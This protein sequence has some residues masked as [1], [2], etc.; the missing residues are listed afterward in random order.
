M[1]VVEILAFL[2]KKGI[3]LERDGGDLIARPTAAATDEVVELIRGHKA[4]LLDELTIEGEVYEFPLRL[5]E[6]RSANLLYEAEIVWEE[7]PSDFDYVRSFE[8][9][10]N[11]RKRIAKW[12]VEGRRVGYAVL[13][14]DA[15]HDPGFP[16]RF[17][18]RVFFLKAHD[19]DSAPAGV[20]SYTTPCEAVDPRTVSPGEPAWLTPRAWGARLGKSA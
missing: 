10:T 11:G 7:D 4:E 18:R 17:T 20:Y 16:G 9:T 6:P 15:P 2:G 12:T 1:T 5:R 3:T 19:R 14:P 8:L 13:R